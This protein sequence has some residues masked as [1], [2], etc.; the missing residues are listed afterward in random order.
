MIISMSMC[1]MIIGIATARNTF[2]DLNDCL[3]ILGHE[4]GLNNTTET[5]TK[6]MRAK[7]YYGPKN[8]CMR[9]EI[10]ISSYDVYRIIDRHDDRHTALELEKDISYR[11]KVINKEF[12]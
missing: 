9:E 1:G 3:N 7:T 2:F 12:M 8:E 5:W 6:A 4:Y 10:Y 11:M